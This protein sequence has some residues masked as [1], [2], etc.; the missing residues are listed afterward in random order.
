MVKQRMIR[1]E[2]AKAGDAEALRAH[3]LDERVLRENAETSF[4]LHGFYGLSVFCPA[5]TWSRDRILAEKLNIAAQSPCC[6]M[7][8]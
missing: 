8:T 4:A 3:R 2:P 7:R 1:A 6:G 5:G